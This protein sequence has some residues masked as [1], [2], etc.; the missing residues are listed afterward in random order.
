[1]I[2][3]FNPKFRERRKKLLE[4]AAEFEKLYKE[5][6]N[7]WHKYAAEKKRLEATFPTPQEYDKGIQKICQKLGI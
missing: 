1:M 5:T 2:N 6:G 4:L 7:I 3:Y